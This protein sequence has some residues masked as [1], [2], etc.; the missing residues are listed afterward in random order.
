MGQPGHLAGP[1][2]GD[3][4]L[5]LMAGWSTHFKTLGLTLS[6]IGICTEYFKYLSLLSKCLTLNLFGKFVDLHSPTSL[7]K[8]IL[9]LRLILTVASE[10]EN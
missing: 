1:L 3:S 2:T 5:Y 7:K 4:D 8:L 6:Y 9:K 10:L